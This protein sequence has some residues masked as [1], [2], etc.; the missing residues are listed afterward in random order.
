MNFLRVT[1]LSFLFAVAFNYA[2]LYQGPA[3][4]SAASGLQVTT[5]SYTP[6]APAKVRVVM[7]PPKNLFSNGRLPD[8]Q[9]DVKPSAPAGSNYQIDPLISRASKNVEGDYTLTN[10]F[11]GIADQGT[12]IPA[13]AFAAVGPQHIIATVNSRFVIMT[14][15]GT[16]LKT[17]ES[18]SWYSSVLAT[19]SP[20]DPKVMYDNLSKRW[21][22]VWLDVNS[23]STVSYYLVSVSHDSSATGIWYNY[24]LSNTLN[25]STES[26]TWSDYQ[27]VGYDA[28]AIYITGNQ[29]TAAGAFQYAKIR[30]IPKTG[31]Y[32][33]TGGKVAW[34]DLWNIKHPDGSL[35]TAFGIRP[36]FVVSNSTNATDYNLVAATPYSTGTYFTI[37][38]IA[39]PTTSPVLTAVNVPVTSYADANDPSQLGITSTFDGGGSALHYE[40]VYRDGKL[41]I[42]HSV[43]SGTNNAFSSVRYVVMD[44]VA[45]TALEDKAMGAD[46]YFHFYP[47]IAVDASGNIA[48]TYTRSATT[49]YA[50]S[51]FTSRPIG[52]TTLTG[53][54]VV[55]AG[56]AT[57]YKTF[58][59]TRNRWG[60][61]SGIWW[62]ATSDKVYT[63]SEYVPSK[64]TWGTWIGELTFNTSAAT[65]TVTSP[66]GGEYWA[67][68][69]SQVISWTSTNVAN[70]KIELSTDN[71][72]SWSVIAA[73]LPATPA[74][75]QW[76]VPATATTQNK[77]R[78]SDVLGNATAST[79]AAFTIGVAPTSNWEVINSQTTGNIYGIDYSGLSTDIVWISTDSGYVCRSVDGGKTFTPAGKPSDGIYCVVALSD[80]IAVVASGPA[81]GNGTIYRTTNGG[82]TWTSVYTATG[83]WFDL[84]GKTDAINLWAISDP[85]TTNG[86]FHIVKSTDS[87]LTWTLCANLPASGSTVA[88]LN[89][90]GYQVGNTIW[91]GLGTSGTTGA[92]KV[93]KSVNGAAGPWT[94]ATTTAQS[95]TCMAFSSSTGAGLVG[96][97]GVANTLN[98]TTNGGGAWT[99]L[100]TALGTPHV[101]EYIQGTSTAY[102]GST[103]GLYKTTD[104]G[105]TWVVET[106]PQGVTGEPYSIKLVNNGVNGLVGGTSGM[107]LR[108]ANVTG[109][110]DSKN[111]LKADA[112]ELNQN[113]PNPFNPSTQIT[114][115]L[116]ERANVTLKVFN[117][118]GQE[119]AV[120]MNGE[121][122]AGNHFVNFE[123]RNLAS[124][125]YLYTLKAG[126]SVSTK[127]MM[128]LK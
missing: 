47:A 41:Y 68:S 7:H 94:S 50:G 10:N 46:N 58:G 9:N 64:D 43:K 83:A 72:T 61:Y 98:K 102:A 28:N 40:A 53:S 4:G 93:Y 17:I 62:D 122:A 73:S 125:L 66:M 55:K 76:A 127:K 80:Q 54:K 15:T 96:F 26:S 23:S 105:T 22:M 120:L 121:Q 70:V 77:I 89:N 60:D 29:W 86:K 49:E 38:K 24:A 20:F 114:Y 115:S 35:P 59:G 95:T 106:L 13:D 118:L 18:A 27:G 57:Y 31:L 109:I 87:G 45:G 37:F 100:T 30:I 71:G 79:S 51:Y 39:N 36:S 113:Y 81:A 8:T 56:A 2:Q 101:F 88:G 32:A 91:F 48:I 116:A 69:T 63:F 74:A 128:L 90:S 75:Y 52:T 119:V 78:V 108:K 19:A 123:G 44:A 103:N 34:T 3:S 67:P 65:L 5:D 99:S 117:T 92:N 124:G 21:V 112:F 97:S 6:N 82:T 85:L 14:K 12:G 33:N 16:V 84:L 104:N 1:L 110:K 11:A 111:N 42:A 25:G 107:L 126:N